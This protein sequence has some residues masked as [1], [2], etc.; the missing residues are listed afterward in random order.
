MEGTK[1]MERMRG[2]VLY[3]KCSFFYLHFVFLFL[4]CCQ[5]ASYQLSVYVSK[6]VID[7]RRVV[8]ERESVCVYVSQ[9]DLFCFVTY[10]WTIMM[11]PPRI[12]KRAQRLY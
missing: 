8:D 9:S 1:G 5:T 10:C 12:K 6:S 2:S 3:R 11:I 7:R 4:F